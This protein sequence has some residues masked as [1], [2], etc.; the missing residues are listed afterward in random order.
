M[1][2]GRNTQ[3]DIQMKGTAYFVKKPSKLS[4]LIRPHRIEDEIPYEI[5]KTIR[6][7]QMD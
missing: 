3:G 2:Y 6:L 4:H 1:K 7:P 5:V